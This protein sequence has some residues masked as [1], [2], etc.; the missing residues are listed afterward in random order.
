MKDKGWQLKRLPAFIF[1]WNLEVHLEYS[2][3]DTEFIL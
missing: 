2:S 1:Y 3:D